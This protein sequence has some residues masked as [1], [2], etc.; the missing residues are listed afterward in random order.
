MSREDR[1]VAA[2]LLRD[3]RSQAE[4]AREDGVSGHLADLQPGRRVDGRLLQSEVFQARSHN[5]RCGVEPLPAPVTEGRAQRTNSALELEFVRSAHQLREAAASAAQAAQGAQGAQDAPASQASGGGRKRQRV[6]S[7]GATVDIAEVERIEAELADEEEA[8]ANPLLRPPP[9]QQPKKK[10]AVAAHPARAGAAERGGEDT[11]WPSK[12]LRVRIVDE[13]G[14]FQAS[15][16]SKG[17]VKRR[18][19]ARCTVDVLLDKSDQ[20]LVGVPQQCLETVVSKS[21]TRV[22]VVRGPHRGAIT[23][24]VER[25][26]KSNSAVVRLSRGLGATE[27]ELAMDDVCEFA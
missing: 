22:E 10:A 11:L 8:F 2:L 5:R 4:L 27:V 25:C 18:D 3:A 12:G 23:D 15:H 1:L 7:G 16:L 26:P 13:D 20:L 19:S 9:G 21:C 24:L 17:V 14:A 6:G